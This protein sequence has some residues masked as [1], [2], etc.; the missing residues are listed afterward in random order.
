MCCN[1]AEI[2]PD[3]KRTRNKAGE[4]LRSGGIVAF[5]T[6]TLYGLGVM[7]NH[8]EA[9]NRLFSI[10]GRSSNKGLPILVASVDQAKKLVSHFPCSASELA[11]YFWPGALTM[12]FQKHKSIPNKISFK[13]IT[14]THKHVH[15]MEKINSQKFQKPQNKYSNSKKIDI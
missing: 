11:D 2:L 6:D 9:I 8:P 14:P 15:E 10:K 1:M 4:L 7:L 12:I 3:S 13:K 5:P